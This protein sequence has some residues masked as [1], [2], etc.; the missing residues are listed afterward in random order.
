MSAQLTEFYQ[1]KSAL[2]EFYKSELQ[3]ELKLRNDL[4]SEVLGLEKR[5]R[6]TVDLKDRE[7]SSLTQKSEEILIE[8]SYY[9][10]MSEQY[11]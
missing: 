8:S 7:I 6:E 4:T 5:L 2:E 1:E 11:K 9:K 3:G 10:K